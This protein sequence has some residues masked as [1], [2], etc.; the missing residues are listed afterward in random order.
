[1]NEEGYM[2]F[3]D[4]LFSTLFPAAKMRELEDLNSRAYE[5][6]KNDIDGMHQRFEE[7]AV[8]NKQLGIMFSTLYDLLVEKGLIT[9]EEFK[10]Q[11]DTVNLEDWV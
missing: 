11:L 7:V 5:D 10:K 2:P 8:R 6:V 1:M 9:R 4:Q 3:N